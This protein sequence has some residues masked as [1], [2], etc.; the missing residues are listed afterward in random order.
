MLSASAAA[1]TRATI[2]S[3][4]LAVALAASDIFGTTANPGCSRAAALT[5]EATKW[6]QLARSATDVRS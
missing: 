2:T 5:T 6:E 4:D 1:G 3:A